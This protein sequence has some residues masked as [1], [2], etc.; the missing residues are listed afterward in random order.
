MPAPSYRLT[1]D[2]QADPIEIRQHTIQQWGIDQARKYLSELKRT[3]CLLA[4][5]PSLGKSRPEVGANVLSF[6][7]VSHVVYY[8]VHEQKII[9][10]AVLHWG[11]LKKTDTNVYPIHGGVQ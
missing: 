6:S 5:A 2:A 4:E 1:P 10:F 3:M 8:I 11:K 9:I 7:H